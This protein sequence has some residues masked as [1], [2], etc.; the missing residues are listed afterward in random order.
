MDDNPN[1]TGIPQQDPAHLLVLEAIASCVN[2]SGTSMQP[3]F[4]AK[5]NGLGIQIT[6]TRPVKVE[7]RRPLASGS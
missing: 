4:A 6:L 3:E 5:M 1:G 2:H 7:S